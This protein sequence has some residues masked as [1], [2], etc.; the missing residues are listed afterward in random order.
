MRTNCEYCDKEIEESEVFESVLFFYRGGVAQ[1]ENR[2][3]CCK[4]C[5]EADQMAH[6]I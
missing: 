6:E 1:S 5:A 3:Y 2:K 4:H